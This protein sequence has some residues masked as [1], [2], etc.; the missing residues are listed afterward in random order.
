MRPRVRKWLIVA[1]LVCL[2]AGGLAW[3]S[4]RIGGMIAPRVESRLSQDLNA[5]VKMEG[6]HFDLFTGAHIRQAIIRPKAADGATAPKQIRLRDIEVDHRLK[7]LLLGEYRIERIHVGDLNTSVDPAFAKWAASLGGGDRQIPGTLPEI[8]VS[9]AVLGFDLPGMRRPLEVDRLRLSA[10]QPDVKRILG[11][12]S[13]SAGANEV[14]VQFNAIPEQSFVEADILVNGFD[15]SFLPVFKFEG[16][17]IDPLDFDTRGMLTGKLIAFLGEAPGKAPAVTGQFTLS[18]LS[19]RHSRSNLA[20]TNGTARI[21]VTDHTVTLRDG[22]FNFAGGNVEIPAAGLQ[23]GNTAL[24]RFWCRADLNNLDLISLGG[25]DAF[26]QVPERFR[27]QV[28]SGT[29]SGS[30]HAQWAP[31]DGMDYGAEVMLQDVSAALARNGVAIHSLDAEGSVAS[32]GRINIRQARGRLFGGRVE[33]TGSFELAG[34]KMADPHLEFRFSDIEQNE[35]LIAMLPDHVKKAIRLIGIGGATADGSIELEPDGLAL[36]LTVNAKTLELPTLPFAL[37]D[38]EAGIKW[39][40][41]TRKVLLEDCRGFYSGSPV[42]GSGTLLLDK[43]VRA[44]FTL[45][46]RYLP[47][48]QP[49]LEWLH[50]DAEPW[51]VAG[52][53]DLAIHAEN[54]RPV[55]HS[56]TR[57]LEGIKAQVDLRNV[58][59][60][61]PEYGDVAQNCYGHMTLGS[62]G[63]Q[64]SNLRGDLY[65][66][67][68]RGSASLPLDGSKTS[69]FLQFETQSLTLGQKLFS[70][71]PFDT[72]PAALGLTGQ[73]KLQG[74]FQ[75]LAD[76][77]YDGGV[78]AVIYHLEMSPGDI[79]ITAAGTSQIH[80]SA[81]DLRRPVVSGKIDLGELSVGEFEGDRFT[82]DFEYTDPLL[83]FRDIDINAYGGTIASNETWINL[84]N[85]IWKTS[86]DISHLDFESLMGAFGIEGR[87]A[88]AGVMRAGLRLSGTAFN[89]ETITGVGEVKIDRGMLY[90]FPLL[91]SVLSVFDLHLP[92]Q[93]PVTN[94]YGIFKIGGG[95]IRIEDLLFTGGSVPVHM[96]GGIEL[97][98][99]TPFKHQRINLLV[100]VAKNK[101][102]LDAIP[103]VNIIKH[104][105]IDVLRRIVFQ[106]RVK[107]T[108]DDYEINSLSS[109]V[110]KPIQKM[111]SLIDKITPSAP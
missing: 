91:V 68:F 21:T 87:E 12:V 27:P 104:Y 16:V 57:S 4:A 38:A 47:L 83:T 29:F 62:D 24:E 8:E 63:I 11:I 99:G 17:A 52:S 22:D 39:A 70:R 73:C 43:P 56:L 45:R 71:L 92:S 6:F 76:G 103:I 111:W 93:S 19:V 10:W 48:Q 53:Y 77:R 35:H 2:L 85:R 69:P 15:L 51:R 14:R 86:T 60:I 75:R 50:L 98:Q 90:S 42:E 72:V 37:T 41:G 54:W 102:L 94:A 5:Q 78:T 33:A 66:I 101:G 28:R 9:R 3:L 61:H 36:A 74:E 107:G 30:V 40:S 89:P 58:N 81:K 100:T 7:A 55:K 1:V 34:N 105:T 25:N 20:L 31:A 95:R 59:V 64:L 23:I 26:R 44:D 46:G 79:P 13:F 108:L 49:V 97:K 84:E 88:P 82:A 67:G 32:S 65:D 96:E 18:G 109:P 80:V 106:A 110:T